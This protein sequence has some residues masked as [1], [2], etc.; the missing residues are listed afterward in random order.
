[1]FSMMMVTMRVVMRVPSRV[2][3]E[4]CQTLKNGDKDYEILSHL[5]QVMGRVGM[6]E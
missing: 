4:A 6:N 2:T 5:E 3:E 1:V